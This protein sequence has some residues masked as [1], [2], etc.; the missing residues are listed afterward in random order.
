MSNAKDVGTRLVGY[1]KEGRN[2]EAIKEL[3][4]DDVVSVEAAEGPGSPREITGKDKVLGKATWWE[5]NHEIHGASVKG[6][7]P[8]GEDRFAAIFDYDV[9]FKPAGQRMQ[10]EEV[11]IYFVK[12]GKV[13]REEFYYSMG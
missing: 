3:Y 13:V 12:D 2:I 4:A 11:A 9:T 8:H 1:C 7:F 5:E 10:M 6:P